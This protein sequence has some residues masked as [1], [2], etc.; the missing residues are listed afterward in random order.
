MPVVG[1]VNVLELASIG[2][3][4]KG[5]AA[6]SGPSARCVEHRLPPSIPQCLQMLMIVENLWKKNIIDPP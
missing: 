5:P 4:G 2:A 1:P 6:R 3:I